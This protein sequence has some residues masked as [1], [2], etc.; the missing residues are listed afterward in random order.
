M[1][2]VGVLVE[3]GINSMQ[4]CSVM[5]KGRAPSRPNSVPQG[6]RFRNGLGYVGESEF[7]AGNGSTVLLVF[8]PVGGRG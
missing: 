1:L 7:C 3:D 5:I 4:R 6:E 2:S 8:D